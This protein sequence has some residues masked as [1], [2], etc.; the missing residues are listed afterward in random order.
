MWL[1]QLMPKR[2]L[3]KANIHSRFKADCFFFSRNS[4][5]YRYF[6]NNK[7]FLR[8][9]DIICLRMKHRGIFTKVS[10]NTMSPTTKYFLTLFCKYKTIIFDKREKYWTLNIEKDKSKLY[11][12][13]N[14]T[15]I[16]LK[17][18]ISYWK[19]LK[20]ENSLCCSVTRI[21]HLKFF[22]FYIF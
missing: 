13:V 7:H 21:I 12:F 17:N 14:K 15:T 16:C 10:N 18:P 8:L 1:S 20:K 6:P 11:S 9:N 19:R 4:V 5:E 2:H 22:R 3:A